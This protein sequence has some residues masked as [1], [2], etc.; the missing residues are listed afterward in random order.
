[1]HPAEPPFVPDDTEVR[2]PKEEMKRKTSDEALHAKVAA[3]EEEVERIKQQERLRAQMEMERT[4]EE[5]GAG[6]IGETVR[7]L[8]RSADREALKNLQ[9]QRDKVHGARM[10]AN[11]LILERERQ[12]QL[13]IARDV[14]MM[15]ELDAAAAR[16]K[17]GIV[18]VPLA[19]RPQ[20]SRDF[21]AEIKENPR[22]IAR[23]HAWL[24]PLLQRGANRAPDMR[25]LNASGATLEAE[26]WM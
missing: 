15:R 3:L 25:P 26:D 16:H 21:E 12:K 2:Y 20:K 1:V 19:P 11:D 13:K 5:T 22:H 4:N 6:S 23:Q 14:A 8:S 17:N 24:Q 9:A 18:N 10:E 7:E